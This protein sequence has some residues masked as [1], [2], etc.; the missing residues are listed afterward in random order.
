MYVGKS[1][2]MVEDLGY[3]GARGSLPAAGAR[4][5]PVPVD[6]EGIDEGHFARHL[7]KMRLLYLERR[8]ALVDALTRELGGILD[9]GIPE[10]GMHPVAWLPSGMSAQ[11]AAHSLHILPLSQFNLR[12]L[13]REGLMLGFAGATPEELRAGVQTLAL[14][15]PAQ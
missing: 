12:P 13:Q 4:L 9:V 7:R 14:A 8:N 3:L 5:V 6:R 10:A 1:Y 11:A 15:L 2:A